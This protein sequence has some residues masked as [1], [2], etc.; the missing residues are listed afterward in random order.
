VSLVCNNDATP[1]VFVVPFEL[2]ATPLGPI[3]NGVPIEIALTGTVNFPASLVNLA[4]ARAPGLTESTLRELKAT[5]VP[6]SGATGGPVALGVGTPP[7]PL[8]MQI[9]FPLIYDA[10]ECGLLGLPT[11]CADDPVLIPMES[12]I[13]TLTPTG[14]SILLGWDESDLPPVEIDPASPGPNA[15]AET[16][17]G[18]DLAVE[19]FMGALDDDVPT[20]LL[21]AE[22]LEIPI[23]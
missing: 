3:V 9:L 2:T 1:D 16:A 4:V 22:L 12:V 19:C 23:N 10:G 14:G 13:A 15:W 20:A 18:T 17:A 7:A 21:D 6:R 5:V 11:P 8:P